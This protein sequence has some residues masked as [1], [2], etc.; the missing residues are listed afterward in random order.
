MTPKNYSVVIAGG[1]MVGLST[2]LILAYNNP[3]LSIAVIDPAQAA[4][5]SYSP[6]FDSRSTAIALG[7]QR[8]LSHIGVWSRITSPAPIQQVHVSAKDHFGGVL[9][10][11][12]EVDEQAVGWVVENADL[13]HALLEQVAQCPAIDLWSGC[14]VEQLA[15]TAQGAVVQLSDQQSL[16]TPLCIIADGAESRLRSQ[17]G[18]S[19]TRHNYQ[20]TALVFNV[21]FD[22]NNPVIAYE[23]F[24]TRGPMAVLPLSNNRR[25]I[26]WSCEPERAE[27]LMAMSDDEFVVAFEAFCGH[28]FGAVKKMGERA[29]YPLIKTISSELYRRHIVLMGNAAHFLHP[30]AGQGFNLCVRD[31]AE[32][33]LQ[34]KHETDLSSLAILNRWAAAVRNDQQLTEVGGDAMVRGFGIDLPCASIVRSLSLGLFG[35]VKPLRS[36][37]IH[38]AAGLISGALK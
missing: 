21:E 1:G 26:V 3:N 24:D 35:A 30:V 20:Q 13:G 23:R 31:A 32:L 22:K 34:L 6:S 7:T 16:S 5:Q 28:R 4:Q 14:S 18:I 29:H 25:A 11:A 38:Q 2:A 27:Q 9:L 12:A 33:A 19:N 10:D 36:H 17:L 8:T 15:I 37:F